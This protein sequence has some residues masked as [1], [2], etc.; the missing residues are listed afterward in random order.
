MK[1]CS[2]SVFWTKARGLDGVRKSTTTP[3]A[4]PS[5][6]KA[7]PIA[8]ATLPTKC[9]RRLELVPI[10]PLSTLD[11]VIHALMLT[12]QVP[13]IFRQPALHQIL[14]SLHAYDSRSRRSNI[15]YV[16]SNFLNRITFLRLPTL[17]V[18]VFLAT[19]TAVSLMRAALTLEYLVMH[20]RPSD[21]V[22][23]IRHNPEIEP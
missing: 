2:S 14:G 12:R 18:F 20:L 16:G 6:S 4:E 11:T 3:A 5:S 9:F 10:R 13:R 22:I 1:S 23:S 7:L 8:C 15:V 21:G 19:F 17:Y